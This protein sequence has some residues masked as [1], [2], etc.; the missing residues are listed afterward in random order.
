MLPRDMKLRKILNAIDKLFAMFPSAS[1]RIV[2][3]ARK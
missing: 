2:L 1:Y 3:V